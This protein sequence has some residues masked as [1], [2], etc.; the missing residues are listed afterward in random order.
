MSSVSRPKKILF[1]AVIFVFFF[2]GLE[3]ALRI[4]GFRY[5]PFPAPIVIWNPHEDKTLRQS[6][7]PHRFT[8]DTLW[9]PRPNAILPWFPDER[10]NAAGYRGPLLEVERRPQTI[11][12]ATLGD[13]STFG[14]TVPFDACWSERLRSLLDDSRPEV[15]TELLNGGV[16]GFT[17]VQGYRRFVD[18]VKPHRP[19][20]V[21]LAF[22]AVNE[23]FPSAL[24]DVE[25]LKRA[26]KQEKTFFSKLVHRATLKLRF[27]QFLH[28]FKDKLRGD[29]KDRG[30]ET[31]DNRRR[32]AIE[33]K[34]MKEGEEA[35]RRVTAEEYGEWIGRIADEAQALGAQTIL[36]SFPRKEEKEVEIPY[37]LQYTETLARVAH[38]KKLPLV[39][40]RAE[41]KRI[42]EDGQDGSPVTEEDLFNDNFH[43]TPRGHQIIAKMVFE[44]A[45]TLLAE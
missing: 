12:I 34:K 40:A 29:T 18:L 7:G 37:L 8:S 24:G 33:Y 31:V 30:Q 3:G 25:K 42:L 17:V 16:I 32:E 45:E 11:R 19:D 28:S 6:G 36:V 14:M 44:A 22:G 10:V 15:A 35:N 43:P 5:N 38:E 39:D 26:A 20:L 9:A 13:S 4:L 21:V 27:L 1:S 23:H 2:G 41:F